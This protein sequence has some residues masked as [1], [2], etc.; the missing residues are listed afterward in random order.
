MDWN[1]F[2]LDPLTPSMNGYYNWHLVALSY[3]M[4]VLASYV[5]LSTTR[6]LIHSSPTFFFWRFLGG[7]FAMGA[8]IFTMHFIGMLAYIMP[9]EMSYNLFITLISLIV[10]ILASCAALFIVSRTQFSYVHWLIGSLILGLGISSMHYIGMSAMNNVKILYAPTLF[11]LSIL[12]GIL[13]SL[14]ALY[15]MRLLDRSNASHRFISIVSALVMGG[16]IAGMHYTGM[17]AAYFTPLQKPNVSDV[18]SVLNP[19]RLAVLIAFLATITMIINLLIISYRNFFLV[20]LLF[21]YTI[22]VFLMVPLGFIALSNIRSNQALESQVDSAFLR[23]QAL[24]EIKNT[25]SLLQLAIGKFV[26]AP[27]TV[28]PETNQYVFLNLLADFDKWQQL[29]TNNLGGQD[30]A[31]LPP[32]LKELEEELVSATLTFFK[33]KETKSLEDIVAKQR[34]SLEQ[35]QKTLSDAIEMAVNSEMEHLDRLQKNRNKFERETFRIFLLIITTILF[36]AVALSIFL[37]YQLSKPISQLKNIAKKVAMGDLTQKAPI[38]AQDELG[39]LTNSFNQMID[40]LNAANQKKDNLMNMAAHDIR[41]PL[42]VIM[43]ASTVIPEMGSLTEKQEKLLKMIQQASHSML[44][45]LNNLLSPEAIHRQTMD[46][47]RTKTDLNKFGQEIFDF[48][49]VLAKQ[50]NIQFNLAILPTQDFGLIDQEKIAQ[51]INNLLSNAF[52][53]SKPDSSV[54]LLIKGDA[55]TLRVEVHDEAGGIPLDEQ[56]Q[57]FSKFANLS[58]KPTGGESSHGLG[59]SLCKEIIEKCHGKI[60][61]TCDPGK[62]S[63][64][65]FEI[66]IN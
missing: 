60:G 43:Q 21:S 38:L 10:A 51:V 3:L 49:E 50:K 53:F 32:Q 44:S 22:I 54:L 35:K 64:F 17:A 47:N 57:V 7:A 59:L 26:A 18:I 2:T 48:N 37:S 6:S 14:I 61:F 45:L 19:E 56:S 39:E 16:A 36:I 27:A 12:I 41:N 63:V 62:G 24:L 5:A 23:V 4:A 28:K 20:K 1:F 9:M 42:S 58:V 8:G 66:P 46:V 29:Y 34:A 33:L 15:M 65:Y 55:T 25:S 13:A 30:I 52:K 31:L 40:S 11:F